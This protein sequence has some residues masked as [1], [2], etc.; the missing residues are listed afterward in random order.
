MIPTFAPQARDFGV[1]LE[2]DVKPIDPVAFIETGGEEKELS[3][4]ARVIKAA[5]E[6]PP[7]S[8]TVK[9]VAPYR[10]LHKGKPYVG[11]DVLEIPNDDE[12]KI[13]FRSGWVVKEK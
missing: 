12:H 7:T 9:V 6:K 2:E 5:E 11:G 13:W 4:A 10:V 3:M 1:E 8:V